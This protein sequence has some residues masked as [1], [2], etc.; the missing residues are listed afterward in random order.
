MKRKHIE[1]Q[2]NAKTEMMLTL[3]R[4]RVDRRDCDEKETHRVA[5]ECE[6]RDDVE[7]IGTRR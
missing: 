6:D 5:S 7:L 3:Y 2:A 1:W 4:K